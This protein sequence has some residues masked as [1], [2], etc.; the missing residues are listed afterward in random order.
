[1]Q[2]GN[3]LGYETHTRLAHIAP[4]LGS[5]K[6]LSVAVALI[7]MVVMWH[8]RRITASMP[9]LFVGLLAGTAAYH[10][11]AFLGFSSRLGPVIGQ[12]PA[13]TPGPWSLL[14][15]GPLIAEP[16]LVDILPAIVT[17][18]LGLALIASIDALLCAQL[19]ARPGD[20][21][22]DSNRQLVRL[23]LGNMAAASAGGITG[24][25]NLGSSLINRACGGRTPMSV[26]VNAAGVLATTAF[27]LPVLAYLPRT[28][29]SAA[30]MVVAI[31]HVDPS[32]IE[33]VR[34]IR[35]GRAA[36]RASFALD[37][38]V[39]LLVAILSIAVD[40]VLA[41]LAGV[42]IAIVLFIV[43]MSGSVVRRTYR[44]DAVPSRRE[45]G[46]RETAILAEHGRRIHVLELEG[47]IF[48]GTVGRLV[49]AVDRALA[50]GARFLVLDLGRVTA[51]D[52]TGGHLLS[53]IDADLAARGGRLVLAGLNESN[54]WGLMLRAHGVTAPGVGG[55]PFP[56]TDRAIEWAE[57]QILAA[58]T[59]GEVVIHTC[60]VEDMDAFRG[61][62]ETELAALRAAL[63]TRHY[64]AGDVVIA[65]GARE[66]DLVLVMRGSASVHV[67]EPDGRVTRVA[68]CSAGT[69]LG[70]LALLDRAPRSATVRADGELTCLVLTEAA[71][72]D[73]K[74]T[75]PT[76]AITLLGNLAREVSGRLRRAT[77]SIRH[78]AA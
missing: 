41:V 31:Q 46:E 50:D 64:A 48:F 67:K 66:F 35:S 24:G 44:G 60:A 23:G 25:L 69:V 56:D 37:L 30:I 33:L 40:I 4:N 8:A 53:Q 68:S 15:L 71:F 5:A 2:L 12:T 49:D 43:R 1:V 73:F 47:A 29:L 20:P 74:A 36:S 14:T 59:G 19:L 57:D 13:A 61:F 63:E 6:P 77:R 42:G 17:G 10:A 26:L 38:L 51:A 54:H 32:T 52:M 78:L 65:E 75:H 58:T 9:P 18:A 7:T 21:P 55:E 70:E 27:L 11:F 45:R 22:C 72:R 76:T 62:D 3:V 28:A 34:R 39:I 16:G